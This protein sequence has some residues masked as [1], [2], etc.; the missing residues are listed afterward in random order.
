MTYLRYNTRQGDTFDKLALDAYMDEK[1]AHKIRK[2]NY[3]YRDYLV[4]P[5]GIELRIP[6]LEEEELS[7]S[8]PPWRRPAQ[9]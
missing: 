5:A 2:A 7:E 8:L 9:N 3:E 4:L 6:I 1:L